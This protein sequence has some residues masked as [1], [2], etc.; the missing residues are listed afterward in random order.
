MTQK[1]WR[2]RWWLP[3][4]EKVVTGEL[5]RVEDGHLTLSLVGRL[6]PEDESDFMVLGDTLDGPVTLLKC[7]PGSS[8]SGRVDVQDISAIHCLQGLHLT[9]PDEPRFTST[10]VQIEYLLG[11]IRKTTLSGARELDDGRWTGHQTA[12]TT[13]VDELT[14]T[15]GDFEFT[16]DI[17][18]N[19]FRYQQYPRANEAHLVNKEWG[20]LKISSKE[21]LAYNGFQPQVK[22]IMDLLT[23][24]AHAPA[25]VIEENLQYRTADAG[26]IRLGIETQN[27]RL[28]SRQIHAPARMDPEADNTSQLEYL[29]TLDDV[30]PADMLPKWLQIHD[31][32]WLACAMLFGLRY[33]SEGYT[34]ARLMTSVTAAEALHRELFPEEE[35]LPPELFADLE[36]R[37]RA[38]FSGNNADTKKQ[39][40]YLHEN[41]RNRLSCKERLLR[42]ANVPDQQAVAHLISDVPRWAKL[43]RD[44]RDG[45]AH[46][47]REPLSPPSAGNAYYALEIN[48]IFVSLVLMARIGV[49]AEVQRRAANSYHFSYIVEQFNQSLAGSSS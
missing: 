6:D 2:G 38:A 44:A 7:S 35:A 39:R 11:F 48:I 36:H 5:N 3:G 30:D 29:F 1:S 40:K 31:Q 25:G 24:V 20:E 27:A 43:V 34:A 47:S 45:V 33:I 14:V 4:T 21:P 16:F 41:L 28:F 18:F 23:L 19:A 26:L 37:I 12:E 32:A 46:A 22:A 13:P 10:T 8:T 17:G 15:C 49:P 42:L 9:S